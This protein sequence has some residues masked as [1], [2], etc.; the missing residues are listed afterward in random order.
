MSH[1][2]V[3]LLMLS[4]LYISVDSKVVIIDT[5]A[6]MNSLPKIIKWI[7]VFLLTMILK[8]LFK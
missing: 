1:L 8:S 6:F 4:L 2:E 3:G 5:V 7:A